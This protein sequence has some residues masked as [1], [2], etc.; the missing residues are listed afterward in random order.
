MDFQSEWGRG[1]SLL[2]KCQSPLHLQKVSGPA[3]QIIRADGLSKLLP[4]VFQN[5]NHLLF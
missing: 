2:T 1:E 5:S 4:E 3:T